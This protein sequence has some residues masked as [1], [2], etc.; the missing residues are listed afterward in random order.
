MTAKDPTEPEIL[1]A[2]YLA[3]GRPVGIS[4][5]TN[6]RDFLQR[7]IYFARQKTNDPVLEPLT[8]VF[9]PE[10]EDEVWIMK[11]DQDALPRRE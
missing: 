11:K 8:V 7:K 3:V 5:R 4:L 1:A 6:D 9:S 10:K 2:L